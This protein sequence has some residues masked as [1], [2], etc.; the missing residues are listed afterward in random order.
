MQKDLEEM[1]LNIHT[2]QCVFEKEEDE[3]AVFGNLSIVKAEKR[4]RLNLWTVRG[5]KEEILKKM[6]ASS[7]LFSEILPLSLEEIFKANI[8]KLERRYPE[9]FETR[10][11]VER[12]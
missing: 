6:E 9:G 10:R 2:I 4:G 12:E 8:E 11:S 3:R 5:S 1:K 7:P